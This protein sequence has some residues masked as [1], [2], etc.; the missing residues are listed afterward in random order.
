ALRVT[1]A[2]AAFHE[3]VGRGARPV[4]APRRHGDI[5]VAT[6]MGVGDVTHTFVQRPDGADER[7]LPGLVPVAGTSL[8]GSATGLAEVDHFAV[9]V[10]PGQIDSTVEF[11]EQLLDFDLIFTERIVVDAQA[12]T[13]K[14]VQSR[15]GAVTLTLIEPDP[16]RVAGHIEEFLKSHGGAGVQHV[17]LTTDNIVDAVDAIGARGV[18][19]LNTPATYYRL[20][21][22]RLNVARYSVEELEQRNILVDEDHDGQL[23]QIFTGSVHPRRTFFLE[24]IERLGARSFGTGNIRAL[25]QAVEL[26]RHRDEAAR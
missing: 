5:V 19:F 22:E 14:V 25:Y 13:T 9:C 4:R 11:Y 3:A 8:V 2:A 6:I 7:V 16:S 15:S 20:L 1:D 21:P 10:E 18:E 26:Q 23:F 24:L 17:A 12:I